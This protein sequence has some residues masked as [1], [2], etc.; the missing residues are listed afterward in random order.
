MG[1]AATRSADPRDTPKSHT[2]QAGAVDGSS[3][4]T[5]VIPPRRF[6]LAAN[7]D[8]ADSLQTTS[9]LV[10]QS[11]IASDLSPPFHSAGY[12]PRHEG[13]RSR[14]HPPSR[15]QMNV[16]GST[17]AA[18]AAVTTDGAGSSHG[19]MNPLL[20][21]NSGS[22]LDAFPPRANDDTHVEIAANAGNPGITPAP[23]PPAL[24]QR[25]LSW[26]EEAGGEPMDPG[27]VSP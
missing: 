1:C 3:P 18:C 4:R 21:S 9:L 16:A 24:R 14:N 26:L 6:S 20:V 19:A 25:V 12:S 10:A 17:F 27:D 2:T 7:G 22:R 13:P 5:E 23:C 11:T 15:R 8:I